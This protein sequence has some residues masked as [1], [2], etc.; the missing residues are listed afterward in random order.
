MAV[1]D[2]LE[3]QLLWMVLAVL[4]FMLLVLFWAWVW[5]TGVHVKVWR[6]RFTIA[7]PLIVLSPDARRKWD[8][9][10]VNLD[11]LRSLVLNSNELQHE[12]IQEIFKQY[13]IIKHVGQHAET[14][15]E[16]LFPSWIDDI[17]VSEWT[18]NVSEMDQPFRAILATHQILM[19]EIEQGVAEATAFLEHHP[20]AWAYSHKLYGGIT[21]CAQISGRLIALAQIQLEVSKQSFPQLSD[22]LRE[23]I[24]SIE[25]EYDKEKQQLGQRVSKPGRKKGDSDWTDEEIRELWREWQSKCHLMRSEEFVAS[26]VDK[27]ISRSHMFARFKQIGLGRGEGE[28]SD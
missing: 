22:D 9:A 14:L 24:A 18:V 11:S 20:S 3:L 25:R 28:L 1:I 12:I 8:T 19:N 15:T 5:P 17:P 10:R 26:K 16:P 27:P 13:E 2:Q 6:W 21:L 4:V 23:K 7:A